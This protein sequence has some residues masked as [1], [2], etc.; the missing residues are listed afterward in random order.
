[1]EGSLTRLPLVPAVTQGG[2]NCTASMGQQGARQQDHQFPPRWSGKQWPKGV[3]WLH[4][5]SVQEKPL[6]SRVE[7]AFT[8][9]SW[10]GNKDKIRECEQVLT[11]QYENQP[12]FL[13]EKRTFEPVSFLS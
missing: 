3:Y 12:I 11:R 6:L 7:Y 2:G 13:K 9:C 5:T 1:M 8:G 10:M 4:G